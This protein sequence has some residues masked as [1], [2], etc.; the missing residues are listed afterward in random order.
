ML[1][2][3]PPIEVFVGLDTL[4][5]GSDAIS[6]SLPTRAKLQEWLIEH[7][8]IEKETEIFDAGEFRKL[9]TFTKGAEN[10]IFLSQ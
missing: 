6:K 2:K 5:A 1:E 7:D 8:R 9:K 10:I 4:R 3:M